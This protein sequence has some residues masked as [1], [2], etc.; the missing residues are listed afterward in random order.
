MRVGPELVIGL[1]GAA[2][3]DLKLVGE[4]FSRELARVEY[5]M[6]VVR[7]S[8]LLLDCDKYQHLRGPETEP[9]DERIRKLMGAGDDLRRT[10]KR[11]D[12]VAL[13]AVGK[14]RQLRQE[15]GGSE[16]R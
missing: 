3:T 5:L 16:G 1:V 9:Q 2:G 11:G 7:L 6:D 12:A 4:L 10:A 14:I 8:D 13:L 15:K